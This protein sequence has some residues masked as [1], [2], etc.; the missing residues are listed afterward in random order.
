MT[1]KGRLR[2][3]RGETERHYLAR[4]IFLPYLEVKER[5][6][7][8]SKIEFEFPP[9]GGRARA[10]LAL[11]TERPPVAMVEIWVEIQD[12]KLSKTSWRKKLRTIAGTFKPRNLYVAITENLSSDLLS[13]LDIVSDVLDKFEFFLIDTRKRLIYSFAWKEGVEVHKISIKNNKIIRKRL[14][15]SLDRF[16]R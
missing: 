2:R 11:I 13:I 10:D 5:E 16:L 7:K 4:K 9:Y 14:E 3:Q 8:R 12:T 15:I 6:L 1:V